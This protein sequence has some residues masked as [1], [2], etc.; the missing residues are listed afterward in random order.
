[1]KL[2]SDY[3]LLLGLLLTFILYGAIIIS[4][5]YYFG[6]NPTE[7]A[8]ILIGTHGSLVT[9]HGIAVF[10]RVTLLANSGRSRVTFT[11]SEE[12]ITVH[13]FNTYVTTCV[14]PVLS[15]DEKRFCNEFR[16]NL[17]L[18]IENTHLN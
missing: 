6:S 8:D 5:K 4:I 10:E 12:E 2:L 14:W 18:I 17:D 15:Q 3:K 16:N 1:M 13:A 9:T 11:S 7:Q